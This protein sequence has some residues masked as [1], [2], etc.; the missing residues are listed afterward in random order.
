MKMK[1]IGTLIEASPG[2]QL[3]EYEIW[4]GVLDY[5]DHWQSIDA[6]LAE[7]HD[8]LSKW[9]EAFGHD[10]V[11][12]ATYSH[13]ILTWLEPDNIRKAESVVVVSGVTEAFLLSLRSAA[14]A[15][16]GAI[17]H[18]ACI[19]AGQ[20]PGGS[21]RALLTWAKKN[22]QRIRASIASVLAGD[23]EWFW[24]LKSL[25]DYIVHDGATP[26]I[27]CNGRQF[28]LW[29]YT[30][31]RGWITREPL[32][33]LLKRRVESL[34][35]FADA[36]SKGI[37][38]EIQMPDDRVVGKGTLLGFSVDGEGLGVVMVGHGKEI[39]NRR[40]WCSPPRHGQGH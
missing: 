8:P 10:L 40:C 23:F 36:A 3:S 29:V 2:E 21:L 37:N 19:K 9:A 25:R 32:L 15:I 24:N 22:P 13:L 11:N 39:P 1:A 20:A 30:P 12:L 31:N 26:N 5:Y 28:N 33:P 34:I 35:S 4:T 7:H 17:S 16:A 14:D 6:R 18:V 38:Q 27:H